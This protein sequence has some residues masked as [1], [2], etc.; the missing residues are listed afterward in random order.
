MIPILSGANSPSP[1][2]HLAT[3]VSAAYNHRGE[4]SL[5]NALLVCSSQSKPLA[6]LA[7]SSWDHLN[8]LLE[9]WH[10]AVRIHLM[11]LCHLPGMAAC[12]QVGQTHSAQLTAESPW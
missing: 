2:K 6:L 1:F 8:S 5:Y 9:G 10:L 7:S 4:V 11:T 3:Q 12:C